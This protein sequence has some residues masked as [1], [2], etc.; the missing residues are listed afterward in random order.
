MKNLHYI[1]FFILFALC[2]CKKQN[3]VESFPVDKLYILEYNYSLPEDYPEDYEVSL[4]NLFGVAGFCELD[5][6]F[7]LKYARR[8]A[9]SGYYYYNSESVVPDSMRN[10]IS[11]VLLKYQTDTT[12]QY[13][14]KF[15]S[16]IYDGNCYRFI[17]Q[18]HNQKDITIKFEP[19]YLPEDLRFIY[20]YLYENREKTVH[21]S[22]YNE[23]FEMFNNQV[24]DDELELP[25]PP[26]IKATIKFTPPAIKDKK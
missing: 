6:G 3:V 9:C 26:M 22:K 25:P 8:V 7:N 16:R 4:S 10:E 14:G 1:I 15:G 12:F 19:K 5:N 17:M 23:L 21:K 24:K 11:N 20:S 13:P 18:K 2:S